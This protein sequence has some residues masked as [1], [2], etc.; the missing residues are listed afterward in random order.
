MRTSSVRLLLSL[1]LAGIA[2]RAASTAQRGRDAGQPAANAA[3]HLRPHPLIGVWRVVRFCVRDSAGRFTQPFGPGPVG[4]F[5]YTP[6]GELSIQFMRTPPVRPFAAGDQAPTDAERREL[7]GAYFG[8][9]GTY[10]IT[11]DS[12]VVHH[13]A[14]GTLPS[15]I[16]TD[17]VRRFRITG[18]T[19]S[20]GGRLL[21]CRVLLRV[22]S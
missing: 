5:I 19:L 2:C 15:Y 6:R 20:I 14:G 7:L 10:T 16:G 18:D 1:T 22:R 8:Y 11:S 21:P 13:V 12:T 3:D 4:Y 9:F 17:Q